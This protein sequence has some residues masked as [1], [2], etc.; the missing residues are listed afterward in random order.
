MKEK[1]DVILTTREILPSKKLLVN[2]PEVLA[3]VDDIS[4]L[5]EKVDGTVVC[6]IRLVPNL[7]DPFPLDLYSRDASISDTYPDIDLARELFPTASL[8]LVERLGRA[9]WKRRKYLQMMQEK[10]QPRSEE[11]RVGK[12]GRERG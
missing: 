7:R 11:R 2:D 4:E 1:T 10:N 5:I 6:L 3:L 9:N 12:E 8:A